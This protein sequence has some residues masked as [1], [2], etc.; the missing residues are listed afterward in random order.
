MI[1]LDGAV[2]GKLVANSNCIS[3]RSESRVDSPKYRFGAPPFIH[4][5]K[6]V[7]KRWKLSDISEVVGKRYNL[8]RQAIE[9]YFYSSKS[10]FFSLYSKNNLKNFVKRLNSIVRKN[11]ALHMEI[12]L[13]P[14]A[15]FE[16]RK[17][18]EA[19]VAGRI[20]NF[21]YLMLLNKYGGRSFND[22]NQ[23]P[24]FPWIIGN[25]DV[26][27]LDLDDPKNYRNLVRPIGAIS[28]L[29]ENYAKEKLDVLNSEKDAAPYQL[30]THCL[31]G[32]IVLGYMF[33]V[34]PFSS[35][36]LRFEQGRDSPTRMFHAI[37]RIWASGNVDTSDNKELV[38]EFF[39]L[40]ETFVNHNNYSYGV[41]IPDEDV[42]SLVPNPHVKV[43]VDQVLMPK[44]AQSEHHFV[45]L[46]V[47]A[48]E[49]KQTSQ[50]LDQWI[51]LL[52]GER[53]QKGDYY[54]LYKSLC[55]EEY[56]SKN[57]D[58]LT[59]SNIA[60]IQEFGSN[61]IKLF[62]SKHPARNTEAIKLRTQ[63]GIFRNVLELAQTPG[64][65]VLALM[66]ICSFPNEPVV[67]I[68][69][70]E[71]RIY[72]VLN[73]QKLYRSN[74][75]YINLLHES[76]VRFERK[77]LRML[78][79]KRVFLADRGTFI[80]DAARA[81]DFLDRGN[82]LVTCRHYDNTCRVISAS[83]GDSFAQITFHRVSFHT[84]FW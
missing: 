3:F 6:D 77:E 4:I 67:F 55:D 19:W 49:S 30:G 63:Y 62:R 64:D 35:I 73:T 10:V 26:P 31:P 53:Q 37:R 1:T 71:Q 29:K 84:R 27:V 54:N 32:R 59:D 15:Y 50:F 72:A 7:N 51:D 78:P 80:G 12:V 39:Y 16:Y 17:F 56:T 40:P 24:I 34:E 5:S 82:L 74:E 28:P 69:A 79:Y 36:L 20:S 21:E 43:R 58:K 22:I 11:K 65:G 48:L 70:Y 18:R 45:K 33:R 9:V 81:F 44:W 52:F 13:E 60:E 57:L 2:F 46:N 75:E 61:P 8:I 47:L 42:L 41:K 23:Y 68:K 14:E 76:P 83:S 25:Y 66:K 38:P